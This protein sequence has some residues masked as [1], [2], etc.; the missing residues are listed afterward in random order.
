MTSRGLVPHA[1][2]ATALALACA[3]TPPN[4]DG[5]PDELHSEAPHDEDPQLSSEAA[6]ALAAANYVMTLD[7]YHA[8]REGDAAGEGF[9]VSAYSL[10]SAFGMLYAGSL[11]PARAQI[12]E[13]FGFDLDG[14]QQHVAHNWLDKQLDSRNLPRNEYADSL[15]LDSANGLWLLDSL[16]DGV[17][18][19][20]LDTLAVHYDAGVGLADFAGNPERER[21]RINAWVSE[22]TNSLI[23]ELFPQQAINATTTLVLANALYL[24]GP[25]SEP[26]SE[27][28]TQTRDFTRLDEQVVQVQMMH[29]PLRSGPY[30]ATP[31][32]QATALLL[33]GG[34]LE[35]VLILP[36]DFT[37]FEANLVP[38][39]L[40]EI[41]AGL[42]E[43]LL[44]LSVPKFELEA[45][46]DLTEEL[47]G[48]GLVAPFT[49][50][51]S[52]D[53]IHDAIGVLQVVIHDTV[54]KVD[55]EGV[56]AA[57]ATGINGDGDGDG[58]PIVP[59]VM[60]LDRPFLLAVRDRPT[61]IVLF[62]G[63]VLDPS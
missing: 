23:P 45:A 62:F 50:P 39:T 35:V 22:R 40:T 24:K 2:L 7:L 3:D 55:E 4:G 10:S 27:Y 26:F 19:E 54:I 20:Y 16:A 18:T 57:A 56:E 63:R 38:A 48:L 33:R 1:L 31:E 52:F 12:A 34:D 58:D 21:Q 28:Q 11:E 44:D 25:W 29:G 32:Y 36:T 43:T 53:A 6:D 5:E 49:D 37:A 60:I 13:T 51:T 61:D 46:F 14:D 59:V 8:L 30:T 17:S 41:F 42:E 47:Q 15:T 9:S